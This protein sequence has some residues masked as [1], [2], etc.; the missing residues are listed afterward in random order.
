MFAGRALRRRVGG[1]EL[2]A[3][4]HKR[5]RGVMW[6]GDGREGEVGDCAWSKDDAVGGAAV[7]EVA[8]FLT[9]RHVVAGLDVGVDDAGGDVRHADRHEGHQADDG[10]VGVDADDRPCGDMRQVGLGVRRLDR[11]GAL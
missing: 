2:R 9:L 8:E 11:A 1:G 6:L 3:D 5:R 10:I 4:K 7:L